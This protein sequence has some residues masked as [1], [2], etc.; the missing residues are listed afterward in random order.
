MFPLCGNRPPLPSVAGGGPNTRR[1][2]GRGKVLGAVPPLPRP[3]RG[4]PAPRGGAEL[5]AGRRSRQVSAA[6]G[7]LSPRLRIA[8][9]GAGR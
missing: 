3:L 5:P 6:R 4:G 2:C 7:R 9:W 8:P 1:P